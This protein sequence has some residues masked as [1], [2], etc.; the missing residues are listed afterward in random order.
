L[1]TTVKTQDYIHEELEDIM[2]REYMLQRISES[3]L[4][5]SENVNIGPYK[6]VILP[7]IYINMEGDIFH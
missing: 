3:S 1:G 5:L 2:L 6:T 4:F 7:V